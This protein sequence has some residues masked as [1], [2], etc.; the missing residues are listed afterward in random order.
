GASRPPE[1]PQRR[2]E[3]PVCRQP[4]R[5]AHP[6]RIRIPARLPAQSGAGRLGGAELAPAG[7]APGAQRRHRPGPHGRR[8]RARNRWHHGR[9]PAGHVARCPAAG[10]RTGSGLPPAPAAGPARPAPGGRAGQ[11]RAHRRIPGGAATAGARCHR[12]GHPLLDHAARGLGPHRSDHRPGAAS[13]RA[14]RGLPGARPCGRFHHAV[15]GTAREAVGG[16]QR[17]A[18]ARVHL[19]QAFGSFAARL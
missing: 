3:H 14:L 15:P 10:H 2:P 6:R 7:A 9:L 12:L 16:H 1:R 5:G 19:G 8:A 17:P 11:C 13:G 4:A 18:G